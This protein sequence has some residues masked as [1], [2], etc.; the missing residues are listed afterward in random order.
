MRRRLWIFL[1]LLACVSG[2]YLMGGH[3][4]NNA[5]SKART[6]KIEGS[7]ISGRKTRLD[8]LDL[9][10]VAAESTVAAV[11]GV[12]V[13]TPIGD[14]GDVPRYHIPYPF[15]FNGGKPFSLEKDPIT[16][17]IDFEKA[18]PVKALNYTGRYRER[19]DKESEADD[20]GRN[21]GKKNTDSRQEKI[22]NKDG[23]DVG[24]NEINTYTPNFHDFL[25]LPVHY[26]SD[27]YGNDKYPLISSS[28]ANTKVQSGSN[29]YSTYNHRP[30]HPENDFY[31][32]PVKNTYAPMMKTSTQRIT[33]IDDF[34]AKWTSITRSSTT[35]TTTSAPP[36]IIT[37]SS[38]ILPS[39]STKAPIVT[40]WKPSST[41]IAFHSIDRMSTEAENEKNL[42]PIEKLHASG[43]AESHRNPTNNGATEKAQLVTRYKD[44]PNLNNIVLSH[45]R[46]ETKPSDQNEEYKDSYDTYESLSDDGDNDSDNEETDYF[47][48]FGDLLK[49]DVT[50]VPSSTTPSSTTTST[51]TAST[52]TVVTASSTETTMSTTVTPLRSVSST[53]PTPQ[54]NV[55]ANKP[56]QF[57]AISH[58]VVSSSLNNDRRHDI[59]ERYDDIIDHE[60]RP[61]YPIIKSEPDRMGAGIVIEST[62]NIVVPPDQDTVS[63]V[64]GNRQNVDGGYYSVGTAIGENPYG[65]LPE[66]DASFWPL[67][68]DPHGPTKEIKH[69]HSPISVTEPNPDRVTQKW[70]PPNSSPLKSSNELNPTKS[71]N[72]FATTGTTVIH[73]AKNPSKENDSGY[74]IFPDD[75]TKNKNTL[76]EEHV[77]IINEADGS[78]RELPPKTMLTTTTNKTIVNPPADGA[79]GDLPQLAEDLMPPAESSRPPSYYYHYQFDTPRPD[80]SRPQRLPLPP[81]IKPHSGMPVSSLDVGIRKRPYSPDTKLPNILPQFRPNAKA[82]HGHRGPDVIG[83][84][85]A[86]QGMSTRIRQPLPAHPSRRPLPPPPS[87]LQRLNPPPPPIHAV[88]LAFTPT[89]KMDSVVLPHETEPT[90]RRFR[91]PLGVPPVSRGGPE[92]NAPS[93]RLFAHGNGG[94]DGEGGESRKE[95]R[96][97]SEITDERENEGERYPEEPP[98]T[99]PRPPLFPKRRTAD[100]PRVATLQMIQHH[101]E[102]S[103]EG[104]EAQ[105]TQP[106]EPVLAN[107]A[108]RR[109]SDGHDPSEIPEQPVYV[110]YPVNTAVNI[111]PDDS[112]EKDGSVVVGTRGPQRPLPPDTL[113]QN[114]RDETHTVY[115]GRPVAL[116]FPYP[117]ER[118]DPSSVFPAVKETPV[119]IPSDQR[120]QQA[121]AAIVN[122]R[123]NEKNDA[124]NVIP[125]LQDFLPYRKKNEAA[126]SVTLHRTASIASSASTLSSTASTST[127]T[128]IAYVY[129]PTH[130]PH[131][132]HR[133]DEDLDDDADA[134]ASIDAKQTVLL[135]SQQPSSSSSSAPAPQNFMA[136]FVASMS[137][138]TP[139]KNGWSV[140]VVEPPAG[141]ERKSDSDGDE[142][143]PAD[144]ENDTQ[145]EKTE[146]DADNFKPQ[147][148]GGFKPLYE[149]PTENMERHDIVDANS[150]LNMPRHSKELSPVPDKG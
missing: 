34:K 76:T 21:G 33:T 44:Q 11:A 15:A 105:P 101:G 36:M 43:L 17:K 62:S 47:L 86:G 30:Y 88:R 32:R 120:Q 29:S 65:G 39:T 69:D 14:D 9:D 137:A 130:A 117:L 125:Y 83:T 148:F 6:G 91:P 143:K 1:A 106:V 50:L 20:E 40:T 75:E 89:S 87:Y 51:T 132:A 31:V 16:G 114:E 25:N 63:F 129:T 2:E 42:L 96:S 19:E 95:D 149:F 55:F 67:R 8:D 10:L 93:K 122:E 64:L 79:T 23:H 134:V 121:S 7:S 18:P 140:V 144:S 71:Q 136:P 72:P 78:I 68:N 27:K 112:N 45:A 13:E 123:E 84:M 77:V 147:L 52:T 126:I 60:Y 59:T 28:Y 138:E 61:N 92:E 131:P 22:I 118:P 133:L 109:K 26:S 56:L 111:H 74:I 128:P 49:E 66:S 37:N 127:S 4:D 12:T 80:H 3:L 113:L 57:P 108:E 98:M 41:P 38:R 116:D 85:P 54:E 141:A 46:P 70:W 145:T 24:P 115:N 94:G 82:S 124:V 150:E 146:F 119:L 107:E 73:D 139:S 48:P 99:P 104:D 110:V 5:G 103:N 142:A 35:T 135:P 97:K 100:P 90:I 58:P 53:L 81:R 102:F